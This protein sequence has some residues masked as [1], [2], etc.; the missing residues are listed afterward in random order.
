MKQETVIV[1]I[2]QIPISILNGILFH[3]LYPNRQ[4]N[5]FLLII[6]IKIDS[7]T[8]ERKAKQS[9]YFISHSPPPSSIYY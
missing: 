1:S 8:V 2:L 3:S 4:A 5:I 9:A 7:D 6:I